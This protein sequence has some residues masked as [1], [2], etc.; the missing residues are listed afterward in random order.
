MKAIIRNIII[1]AV[2]LGLGFF[3]YEMYFGS[4]TPK[5][6]GGLQT[7]AGAG[8]GTTATPKIATP[9]PVTTADAGTIGTDFLN[10]LLSIESISLD[11]TL[12]TS[13]AF[14]VLQDFNRPIPADQNPGRINPFAPIGTD[15]VAS[16]VAVTTSIP[17]SVNG[18]SATLNGTL[19]AGDSTTTR[20][21]EYGPT[22]ALGAMTKPKPQTTQG[23]FTEVITK[24]L[25]NTTYYVR[26]D[27]LVG[28]VTVLGN[29]LTWKTAVK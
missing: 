5:I 1:I 23:A 16:T 17:S 15:G 25:P 2:V 12:F 29:V 22:S 27:A 11:D 4:A 7:T 10:T 6:T 3:G 9:N 18:T 28:G 26:A 21:F 19:L 13:K 14:T 24:L 20:W 8:A